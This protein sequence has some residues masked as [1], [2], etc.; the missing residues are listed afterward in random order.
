MR[1]N[2]RNNSLLF[3][4]RFVFLNLFERTFEKFEET[5]FNF[6][7]SHKSTTKL[8]FHS[9]FVPNLADNKEKWRL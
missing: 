5:E 1:Q 6:F 7:P 8:S 9:I 2:S 4:V 3:P